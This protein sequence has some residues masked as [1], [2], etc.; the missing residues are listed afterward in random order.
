MGY[1]LSPIELLIVAILAFAGLGNSPV[2]VPQLADESLQSASPPECLAYFAYHGV[3]KPEKSSRN[4]VEQLLA[5]DEIQS[6]ASEL[7]RLADEGLSVIPATDADQRTA[8]R[9]LPRL[10]KAFLSRPSILYVSQVAVPPDPPS[11]NG[12]VVLNAGDDFAAVKESLEELEELYCRNTPGKQ[13]AVSSTV[14]GTEL[15]RLPAPRGV[16]PVQ[17]GAKQ[18]YVFL[19]VGEGEAAAVVGRLTERGAAPSWLTKVSANL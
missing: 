19:A 6:F 5:E 9:V 14:D 11:G 4:Q 15:R 16:P 17:W 13:S 8:L 7:M 1:G 3:A 10:A 2:G 12:A 18:P